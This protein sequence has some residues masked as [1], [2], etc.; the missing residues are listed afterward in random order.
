[1]VVEKDRRNTDR[2]RANRR[3]G[4]RSRMVF[5]PLWHPSIEIYS[6]AWRVEKSN[7]I[8]YIR[9]RFPLPILF[10]SRRIY[11]SSLGKLN[12]RCAIMDKDYWILTFLK[13]VNLIVSY[14]YYF[15]RILWKK[16]NVHLYLI[17]HYWNAVPRSTMI[18][19]IVNYRDLSLHRLPRV[20]F[21]LIFRMHR[22]LV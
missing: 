10:E 16:I 22:I 8:V 20:D 6:R 3:Q 15:I 14:R 2:R 7:R 13:I 12:H 18:R 4:N 9:T 21:V 11:K 1:M 17:W 19:W 5:L